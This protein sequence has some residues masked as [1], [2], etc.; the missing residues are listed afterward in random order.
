MKRFL[1]AVT[2]IFCLLAG[3]PRADAQALEKAGEAASNSAV[4]AI[5]NGGTGNWSLSTDWTP[6]GAPNNG[7]NTYNVTIGTGTDLVNLNINATISSLILGNGSGNST[8]QNLAGSKESLSIT[9]A[10][11]GNAASDFLFGNA[12]VLTV[13]GVS[14]NAGYMDFSGAS[15]ATFTG[16]FTNTGRID[17]NGN[18]SGGAN[19]LTFGKGF[20]NNAGGWLNI[21]SFSDTADV[22]EIGTLTNNGRITI[23]GDSTLNLTGQP[24]GITEVGAG[25]EIDLYGTFTAGAANAFAQLAGVQ[26]NLYVENGKSTA[27]TPGGGTLSLAAGS[28]TDVDRGT[29]LTITGNVNSSGR[30]DTNGQNGDSGANSVTITGSY[31]NN[32]GAYL[33][34][35]A[36]N[37]TADVV[38]VATLT[39]NGRVSIG[40]DAVLN[41]TGQPNG[42][43]DVAA[44][45]EIDLYGTFTAGT[46]AAF[47]KLASIEGYLY[48]ENG[49]STAV[50]PGG[51]SLNLASASYL[52]IDRGSTLAVSGNVTSSGRLDTNGVNGDAGANLLTVTGSYTNNAGGY[53]NIGAFNDTADVVSVATLTN[54]G[55]ITI[56]E[57]STLNLTRQPDGVTDVVAGSEVDLYG[58]FTAGTANAFAKL[59]SV[60]GVL[61]LENQQSTAIAPGGGTLT[62]AAGSYT[63]VDRGSTVTISGNV[64][65][66]GRLDTNGADGDAGANL[67]TV[68]G[69]YTNN[70]GGYLNIGAYN[71]TADVVNVATLINNGRITIGEE[72]VLNLTGQPNGVTDVAAGSEIDLY[73]AFTAGTANALANLA[74]VEGALYIEN[75]KSTTVTPGGGTLTLAAGSYTDIDRGTSVTISGNV[76]SSGRLDT[77]GANGAGANLLT[78]SGSYTNNAGA[79]LNIGNY[80]DTADVVDIATLSNNGR[81]TIGVESTL[82]LTNQPS[83]ITD[84]AAG[85]EIDLY[86]TFKAGAASALAGLGSVEGALYVANGQSTTVTAGNG[87]LSVAGTGLFDVDRASNV[88][89]S[90][91][92]NNSGQVET[93]GTNS[94]VGP[95][96]LTVTGQLINNTGATITVGQFN[97]TS[98]SLS[99]GTL[100]NSGVVN[101]GE[102]ATL[103]LTASGTSVNSGAINLTSS[104]LRVSGAAVTLSGA[105]TVTLSA[106]TGGAY[107]SITGADPSVSF[108][109]AST[110]EGYGTISNMGIVNTGTMLANQSAPLVILPSSA[111]LTNNGTLS[112]LTGDTMQ[113]GTATGGALTNFSGTTLTGGTYSVGG[114]MQFG[115]AGSTIVTDAANI[116][117]AGAGAQMINFGG[118]NLLADLAVISGAGSLSLGN[119]WGT[120]TTAGNFTN[121]GTLSVGAGDKFI[122][123]PGDSLTN[124]SGTT[125]TGG[126]FKITGTLEFSGANIVTNDASITLSGAASKIVTKNGANGLANFAVNGAGASFTLGKGRSLTTAGNFTNNGTL[127]IGPGDTF[128]VNGNLT[129]FSGTTLTGGAYNVSG[130][131]QFNGANIVTN[132]ASINLGSAA[133]QIVNQSS[134]NALLGFTT[135]TAGGKFALSG[136]A[137]LATT[138]GSFSNA[139]IFTV[140]TGSTFT[141]GGGSFNFTQ[142]A[143]TATVDGTLAAAGSGALTLNGGILYGTGTLDYGVVDAATITPG[144]SASSTGKLQVSGTYAQSGGGALDVT[145]GGTTAGTNYDQL[146]V[147]G[148]ASL[149]GILNISLAS[150]FTPALGSTF[151][152]LNASSISGVFSTVNGLAINGSE[153]FTVTTVSGDE[154]VLTVVS[155][156]APALSASL[157]QALHSGKRHLAT[158]AA[159]TLAP[160]MAPVGAGGAPIRMPGGLQVFRPREDFGSPLAVSPAAS[161]AP[162]SAAAYNP[163]ASTNHLRFECGVDLK[164]LLKTSRKQLLKGLLA[165]PDSP[166]AVNIGYVALTMR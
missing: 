15:A 103:N 69:S 81:I 136:N 118:Q 102:N 34:I 143:G 99:T 117:L 78:I 155:G 138:G 113:I 125:L 17:T 26:G 68:T 150:G 27:D 62:L 144:N 147:S 130:I 71:N 164:A 60:E 135:N 121:S 79:Y 122:V 134:G 165:A 126:V 163:M 124:F 53:L 31:T 30:L 75:Q 104:T 161:S 91:N 67:V 160:V 158:T 129:N 156:A 146:N 35:G 73:G 9:G 140:S 108:T 115:A 40:Q 56:G 149:N 128:D 94:A 59:A 112:V 16:A 7:A 64:T 72:S 139:G 85:S 58:T 57:K 20:T 1:V 51:G 116:S 52:D 47:A 153:H 10:F 133:A 32:A 13:G 110:I 38:N 166:D 96:T 90:G 93:N 86:G 42:V 80:N 98:D 45:S 88:T 105:G 101:V 29:S 6:N 82:N 48:L 43:T 132:S 49:K 95:N 23:G 22:V 14:T 162:A 107:S 37:D 61:Y 111:G 63:D 28:Y 145:I 148:T 106:A 152:I 109:N 54:N 3:I 151:D 33:N 2:G 19:M 41:L 76:N 21:G 36:Y 77:N 141:V 87:S 137:A 114:T 70:A 100:A 119:S 65:S 5:W 84:V 8:L 92:L 39:N 12:S 55:R 159:S 154:I 44:G 131:L 66:S 25:S 83:G 46:S 97:D 123:N 50:T 11:T 89:V 142:S 4:N 24:N 74:S 157:A 127:A 18:N 120:F